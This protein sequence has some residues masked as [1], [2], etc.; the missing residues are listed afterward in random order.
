MLHI[1]TNGA[2]KLGD[3]IGVCHNIT[4]NE[5]VHLGR[6]FGCVFLN[7]AVLHSLNHVKVVTCIGGTFLTDNLSK[8]VLRLGFFLTRGGGSGGI[9]ILFYA[10]KLIVNLLKGFALLK[11]V[12]IALELGSVVVL[13]LILFEIRGGALK[14]VGNNVVLA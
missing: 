9:S 11:T 1:V 6:A 12:G 5:Y 3:V 4:L 14:N 7:L 8:F 10:V 13:F 2:V